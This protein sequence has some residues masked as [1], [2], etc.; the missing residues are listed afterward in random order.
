MEELLQRLEAQTETRRC[1]F[2]EHYESFA[3]SHNLTDWEGWFSPYTLEIYETALSHIA[4]DDVVLEIGAGD[5]RLALRTA[6]RARRV[7]AVE[8]NPLVIGSALETIGLCMPDNLHVICANALDF[9]IPPG[10][11]AAV[12]LMRHCQH[13]GEYFERL[14][15]AGC[16]RLLTNARW[17][18]GVETVD[19]KAPRL[20]FE[21]VCEG[22]Y[23]CRCGAVGYVGSGTRAEA[24]PVEVVT[25]PACDSDQVLIDQADR[26]VSE[27]EAR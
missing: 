13:F 16:N 23:A 6:E 1:Q 21:E 22:W 25:C 26:T 20:P 2:H 15:T 7:Y 18:S 4:P 3:D 9:P 24:L 12:L 17:K 14:R 19:L 11:T 5:L 27:E 10:V 8:I